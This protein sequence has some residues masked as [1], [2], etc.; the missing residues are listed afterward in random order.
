VA[1]ATTTR[2]PASALARNYTGPTVVEMGESWDRSLRARN[3]RAETRR[4][5]LAAVE[6][7]DAFLP[8]AECRP[9]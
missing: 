2:A 6:Q 1:D 7:F 4:T 9:R 8:S 3:A 5:Y